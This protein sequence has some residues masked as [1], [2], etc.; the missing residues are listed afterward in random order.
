MTASGR[1]LPT[2][3]LAASSQLSE[4]HRP[5]NHCRRHGKPVTLRRHADYYSITSS[6]M[7]RSFRGTVRPSVFA[8]FRLITKSNFAGCSTGM[9]AGFSPLR[10]HATY[11]LPRRRAARI[12]RARPVHGER[13]CRVKRRPR[14]HT[15]HFHGRYDAHRNRGER[16]RSP[17]GVKESMIGRSMEN[18]QR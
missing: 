7:T 16:K 5:S 10:M 6:A 12:V 14:R 18:S 2:F 17:Q 1:R 11:A 4:V 9:S 15:H 3:A 13:V 8:V